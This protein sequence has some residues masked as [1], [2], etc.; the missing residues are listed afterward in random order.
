MTVK[1]RESQILRVRA[2]GIHPELSEKLAESLSLAVVSTVRTVME[3]ALQE[4]MAEFLSRFEGKKPQ[5]SGTYTR[6][7]N[8]PY[9]AIEDLQVPKLRE[10]NRALS[11]EILERFRGDGHLGRWSS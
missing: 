3:A 1:T 6:G 5:R 7:L 4:E 9:G 8:T 2:Q 11:W 10:R